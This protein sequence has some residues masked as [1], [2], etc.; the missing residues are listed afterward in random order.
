MENIEP[1]AAQEQAVSPEA[2]SAEQGPEDV[3]LLLQDARNKADEHWNQLLRVKADLENLRRRGERDLEQAHRYGLERFVQELLP[4]KDSLE[5]GLTASQGEGDAVKGLRE[6][7]ELTRKMLQ[8]A[9]EKFGV[10]ELNPQGERF[11]PELHQAMSVQERADAEPNTV[12]LVCQKGYLLHDRLI[13]PAMVIVSKSPE[14]AD[15]PGRTNVAGGRM[16][17][18]TAEDPGQ[19]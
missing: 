12:L 14:S 10:K 19:A 8:N 18:A 3:H 6:G 13:R 17:G 5:L 15:V 2:S 1:G 4:V 7:M 16:P 9:L 11:N